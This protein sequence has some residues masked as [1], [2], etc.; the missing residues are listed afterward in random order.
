M[1][2]LPVPARA[3]AAALALLLAACSDQ[4]PLA[5]TPHTPTALTALVCTVDVHAGTMGCRAQEPS[6]G[7]NLD[8]MYGGQE[9]YVK[10]ASAGTTFDSGTNI[11]SSNVTV[12]NLLH[13]LIGTTD[14]ATTTGVKVFFAGEP[15]TTGGSGSV[16]VGN[17]D[18]YD[19]FTA[20]NQPY[21]LYNEILSPLQI[22]SSRGWQFN[23]DA[24]VTAFTFTVYISAPMQD[25]SG[26]V[27][28]KIDE[29][30]AGATS[31][32]WT[33]A[34]NWSNSTVPDSAKGVSIPADSLLSPGHN[35]PVLTAN[36][37]VLHLRVGYGSTLGEGGFTA[38]VR[39]NVDAV[40]AISNGTLWMTGSG[41]LLSGNVNALQ[42]SGSTRLQGA[43]KAT[44]AVVVSGSLANNGKALT[45]SIP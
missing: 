13:V 32:D 19:L 36:V 38:R 16:V 45:I 5:P 24:T 34:S 12:Q 2:R 20:S 10:L 17:P 33:D 23:L 21:F 42:V 31:T 26:S 40:G 18:G 4:N 39:G 15:T 25:E 29:T 28:A 43:T 41:A 7:A 37:D 11:L 35:L 8:V 9:K 44:G 1:S 6:A 22:S 27:A 14:G 30:W 3:G